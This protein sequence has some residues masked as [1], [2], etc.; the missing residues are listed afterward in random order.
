MKNPIRL[1]LRDKILLGFGSVLFIM[2]IVFAV[3]LV[4]LLKLGKA[5]EAILKQNYLSIDATYQ[6]LDAI[7]QHYL[8]IVSA[9]LGG[10][11]INVQALIKE[12]LRFETWMQM[13]RGNITEKGELAAVDKLEGYYKQYINKSYELIRRET[14]P[15]GL[16]QET[17]NTSLRPL[18]ERIRY[19]NQEIMSINKNGMFKSSE[20][21]KHIAHKAT[22]SLIIIGALGVLL[23]IVLSLTL[24]SIIVRPLKNMLVALEKVASGDYGARIDHHS[25]DELGIVSNEFNHMVSKLKEYHELNIRSILKEKQ[26]NEALLLNMEDGLFLLDSDFR[27]A[28][29]NRSG[30]AFFNTEVELCKGRHI[31]EIIRQEQ[32][33]E[34]IKETAEQGKSPDIP[35]GNNL[36]VVGV[37][38]AKRFLQ[39][40]LTPVFEKKDVL[41]G[42]MILIQDITHLKQLDRLKSEFLMIASHELKTPLT[43]INMSVSLLHER[44]MSKLSEQEQELLQIALDDT[45]RLKA[46]INDLLDLSKIEAG[47]IDLNMESLN[48]SSVIAKVLNGFAN[49]IEAKQIH[50]ESQCDQDITVR[51]DFSKIALILTN[52]VSNALRFTAQG[53]SI[54]V[55]AELLGKFVQISVA[56]N[57]IGIPSE[58]HN[59]LFDKF[60]QVASQLNTGGTGLGLAISKEIV[61][62]HGG[63]IWVESVF[64]EGSTFYFTLPLG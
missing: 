55:K 49:A 52:L 33:F 48:V 56:D 27:V 41:L 9:P 43:S 15:R 4:S 47:K 22:Y 63:S 17:L 60:F 50:L 7:E 26:I 39:F 13:E 59:R 28:N 32:L 21:A 30:A 3:S 54:A 24:S 45:N 51:G 31:L 18:V 40:I 11:E 1:Q 44:A 42:V 23:S 36:I 16:T 19:Y 61:R 25:T 34:Y 6:M 12:Q 64:G 37:D 58:Y 2:L 29:V 62:A 8:I 20:Q 46:L 10:Q 53:G 35:E 57:G 38:K 14:F 5:S